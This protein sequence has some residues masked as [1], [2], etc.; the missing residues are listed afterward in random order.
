[1]MNEEN[2]TADNGSK[3]K[4]VELL[5]KTK[6]PLSTQ[7]I[8]KEL[9]LPWHSV[10]TRCLRLQIEDKVNGFRIGRMNLWEIKNFD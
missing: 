8:A 9:E 3:E 1:M 7:D 6:K 5:S 2:T 10:Q 4:I